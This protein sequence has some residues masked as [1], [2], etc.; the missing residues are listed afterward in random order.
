MDAGLQAVHCHEARSAWLVAMHGVGWIK[1]GINLNAA[2]SSGS[3][4]HLC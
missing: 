2:T 1:R 4:L 3:T